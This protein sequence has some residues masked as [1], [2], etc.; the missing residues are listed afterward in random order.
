[1]RTVCS[2]RLA[3]V[4][5]RFA[6]TTHQRM[7][8]REDGLKKPFRF[9]RA[10]ASASRAAARMGQFLEPLHRVERAPRAVRLRDLDRGDPGPGEQPLALEPR[11][12]FLV[13]GRR[14]P[15]GLRGAKS[16]RLRRSS[17]R[18]TVLSIQPK[19]SASSTASS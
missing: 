19:Q 9:S 11:H 16:W 2:I 6:L 3:R 14:V 15:C 12:T 8:L 7:P 4:S 5:G 17:S 18:F 13:R 1:M 10:A